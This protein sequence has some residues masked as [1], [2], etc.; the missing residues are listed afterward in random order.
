MLTVKDTVV[1]IYIYIYIYVADL[2]VRNSCILSTERS[3]LFVNVIFEI[4]FISLEGINRLV[5]VMKTHWIVCEMGTLFLNIW[6]FQILILRLPPF[7]LNCK[8]KQ[9]RT[10]LAHVRAPYYEGVWGEWKWSSTSSH[11]QGSDQSPSCCLWYVG[12]APQPVWMLLQGE[13]SFSTRSI[14]P[15]LFWPPQATEQRLV[16]GLVVK[17][18]LKCITLYF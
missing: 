12:W 9:K 7:H 4:T 16:S 15:W 18:R 10:S 13:K 14:D 5:V 3:H 8:C 1:T 2:S 11:M 17:V 6:G